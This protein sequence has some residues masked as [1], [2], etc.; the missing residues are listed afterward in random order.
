MVNERDQIK[1]GQALAYV[2]QLGTHF[3][4]EAPQAGEIVK[5]TLE[6]GAPVE[7]QQVVVEIAPFFGG[8]V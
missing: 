3:P 6:D 8:K 4:I 5:F 1:K 7:F 2:E